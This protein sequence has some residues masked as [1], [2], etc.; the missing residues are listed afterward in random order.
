MIIS[1]E[2]SRIALVTI[3]SLGPPLGQYCELFLDDKTN[4]LS[5]LKN[6]NPYG[7]AFRF[8]AQDKLEMKVPLEVTVSYVDSA[9]EFYVHLQKH[10]VLK[11][12]DA[13]CDELFKSMSCSHSPPVYR[14]PSGKMLRSLSQRRLLSWHHFWNVEEQY[15]AS[16][17]C[18]FRNHRGDPREAH[19]PSHG[20]VHR[21]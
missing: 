9:Q 11:A 5:K 14:N 16:E 2:F 6:W 13:S 18:G 21:Y 10:E 15:V 7:D 4:I 1:K 20:Q 8:R 17:A 12:Y 19:L 3:N